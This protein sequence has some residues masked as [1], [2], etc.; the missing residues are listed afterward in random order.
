V[1][2]FA[3]AGSMA[4]IAGA[5]SAPLYRNPPGILQYFSFNSL[6]YVSVPILAGFE[7]IMA[8][9]GVAIFF[10]LLPQM[11]LSLKINPQ[12]LGGIGLTVGVLAG[13]RGLGGLL[14][15]LFDSR[16]R[17]KRKEAKANIAKGQAKL[18]G[19]GGGRPSGGRPAAPPKAKDS[20]LGAKAP[21]S[22]GSEKK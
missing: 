11:L 3:I 10:Q 13:P 17:A 21:A 4:G 5:L 12:L 16:A 15:D 20:Q 18:G 7:S 9:V 19:G 14:I 2:A 22:A 6:F 8:T 1:A